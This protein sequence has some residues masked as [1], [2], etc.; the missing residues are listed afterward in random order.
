MNRIKNTV[1]GKVAPFLAGCVLASSTAEATEFRDSEAVTKLLA[2]AKSVASQLK[3]DAVA[4][5]GFT[6]ANVSVESH[7]AAINEIR[8]HVN[9]LGRIETKLKDA[10]ETAAP[11]QKAAVDR[12]EP[13]LDELDGY[14]LAVIEHIN[15]APKHT[16]AEYKDFLEA[17][18]DYATDLAAMI[19]VFVDYGKAKERMEGLGAKLE[20]HPFK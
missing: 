5:E 14:T 20:V 6:R 7:A 10:R 15:G 19:A 18:A 13:Y 3:A 16:F 2:E 8:E 9:A 12:I 17:N 11:W 4:M 1:V